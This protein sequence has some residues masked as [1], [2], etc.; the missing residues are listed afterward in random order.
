[1]PKYSA[2]A[3]MAKN[4]VIGKEN[5][6]PWHLSEDLKHFKA[7][8]MGF[9]IVMG[10]KTFMS[11]GRAL[12]GR[13]NIVLTHNKDFKH[14]GVTVKHSI[15]DVDQYLDKK[16]VERA[17][18]IGGGE[19]YKSFASRIDQYHL[20]KIDLDVEGDTFFPDID[21]ASFTRVSEESGTS[22]K[23]PHLNYQFE[24][25]SRIDASSL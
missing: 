21:M 25:Y 3:A 24:T 8:T 13:E 19:I 18:V 20:T 11:L 4:K 14:E 10:R 23:E 2:I 22:K 9:P 16:N 15:D 7:V 5:K 17:F 1:M 12:P 6:M